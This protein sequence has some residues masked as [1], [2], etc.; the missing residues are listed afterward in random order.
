M[1]K[2][3]L[4]LGGGCFWCMEAVFE[5]LDGVEDVVSGY[6]NGDTDKPDYRSVCSGTT[7]YAEVVKITYNKDVISIDDLLKIFFELHDPTTL[8]RQ[9]ADRGTQYRSTILYTNENIKNSALKAKE[10]AQS[11]YCNRIVTIIE[12]LEKFYLAEDYHQDYY[13]LNSTQGYCMGVISPKV[14]KLKEKHSNL[15]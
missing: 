2:E 4:V 11:N 14:L 3:E 15:L 12:P 13:R 9:G 10:L 1:S 7:G 8:N 5:L 6:A